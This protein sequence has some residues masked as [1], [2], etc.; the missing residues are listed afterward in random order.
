MQP[1]GTKMSEAKK[2][3]S[4]GRPRSLDRTRILEDA[5]RL[6]W[7]E[8]PL[9]LSLNEVCRRLEIAKPGLYR[10]FGGEDGLLAACL[11]LYWDLYMKR[12]H[13]FLSTTDQPFLKQ[14][15]SVID[16]IAGEVSGMATDA[17]CLS[18]KMRSERNRLGPIARAR[19]EQLERDNLTSYESWI[20]RAQS[21]GTLRVDLDPSTLASYVDAQVFS[22]FHQK[23]QGVDGDII[24]SNAKL[25]FSILLLP[26]TGKD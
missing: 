2:K 19:V 6:Y 17:G 11:D 9:R 26:E 21:E 7:H 12:L 8:G 1:I 25:A 18:V 22:A 16:A 5:M 13:D 10:E 14:I 4:R 15:E 23:G 20:R 24:R 3:R